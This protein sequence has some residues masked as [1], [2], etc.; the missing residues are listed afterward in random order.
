MANTGGWNMVTIEDKYFR[1]ITCVFIT[2]FQVSNTYIFKFVELH[3]LKS[4][5]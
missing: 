1:I 3:P 4:Y 2:N 5:S